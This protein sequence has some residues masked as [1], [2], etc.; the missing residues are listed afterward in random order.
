MANREVYVK[1]VFNTEIAAGGVFPVDVQDNAEKNNYLPLN[2]L[3][4]A[5]LDDNQIWIYLDTLPASNV[6]PDYVL[7]AEKTMDEGY[8]EGVNFNTLY[9]VNKGADVIAANQ[10]AIR[11]AKVEEVK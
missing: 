5:N 4:V 11:V 7:G 6:S 9:I 3:R 1:K 2:K 10:I 8:E